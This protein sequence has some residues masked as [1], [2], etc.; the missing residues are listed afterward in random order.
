M[1]IVLEI[2]SW[3]LLAVGSVFLIIGGIGL[4]R[5]PDVFAR[6]HG[7]GIIETMG[8]GAVLSG[9]MIQGGLSIV[10]IKLVLIVIFILFTSPTAT[11]ALARAALHG[12]VRPR[13]TVTPKGKAPTK[14]G[15]SSKT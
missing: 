7:A 11:H 13:Q 3:G 6:M 14:G 5:L 9:L 10:T 15:E 1:D 8:A 4:I 12:G 2:L